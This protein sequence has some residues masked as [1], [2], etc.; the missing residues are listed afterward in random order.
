MKEGVRSQETEVRRRARLVTCGE[1]DLLLVAGTATTACSRA[2]P[3]FS[4]RAVV[5]GK[6]RDPLASHAAENDAGR[7]ADDQLPDSRLGSGAAEVGMSFQCFYDGNEARGDSPGCPRIV[8]GNEC[9]D[10]TEPSYTI[11]TNG[12]ALLAALQDEPQRLKP[13]DSTAVTAWLKP[14]PDGLHEE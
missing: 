13:V 11:F 1:T 10:F 8:L 12:V 9:A 7:S 2:R 6:N 5:D 14:C 3:G 4:L